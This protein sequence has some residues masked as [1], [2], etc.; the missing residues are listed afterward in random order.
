VDTETLENN[1]VTIRE[2]DTMEQIRLDILELRDYI[3]KGIRPQV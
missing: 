3:T 2:R 1:T